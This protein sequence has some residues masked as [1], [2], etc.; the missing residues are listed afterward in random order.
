M[1]HYKEYPPGGEPTGG[2]YPRDRERGG[3]RLGTGKGLII[4][5]WEDS[6]LFELFGDDFSKRFVNFLKS[7]NTRQILTHCSSK[8]CGKS[9][10]SM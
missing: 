1:G 6:F 8:I 7:R 3:G 9:M 10:V 2:N 5:Y 4:S